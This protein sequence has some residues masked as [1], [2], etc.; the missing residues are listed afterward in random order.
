MPSTS[1]H[2]SVTGACGADAG[3]D[4]HDPRVAFEVGRQGD[5]VEPDIAVDH[6]DAA[7]RTDRRD[8]R[9]PRGHAAEQRR[10]DPPEILIPDQPG[11]PGRSGL[12]AREHGRER[13][14][15]NDD[16]VAGADAR[17]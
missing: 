11:L 17:R 7:P 8:G 6:A 1:S 13:R 4:L 9:R 10:A 5:V 14:G 2:A 15:P 3:P 12:L 16:L